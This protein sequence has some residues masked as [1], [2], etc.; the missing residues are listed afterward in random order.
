LIRL[1]AMTRTWKK[2]LLALPLLLVWAW[3]VTTWYFATSQTDEELFGDYRRGLMNA[4]SHGEYKRGDFLAG[5]LLRKPSFNDDQQLLYVAM[6]AANGNQ[7]LPR[8]DLLLSRLTKESHYG[9]AHM[10]YAQQLLGQPNAGAGNLQLAIHHV[11]QALKV[12]D[13]PE[14]IRLYLARLYYQAR[15]STQAIRILEDVTNPSYSS[16]VLLAKLYLSTGAKEKANTMAFELLQQ[17]DL[18]DPTMR[19]SLHE[20]VEAVTVLAESRGEPSFVLSQVAVIAKVLENKIVLVPE[21]ESYQVLLS[22]LY[23]V[24]AKVRLGQVD[25][26]SRGQGLAD[27]QKAIATG[28]APYRIGSMVFSA[29]N[30]DSSGGL[31]EGQM[32][33]ALVQ[34]RGVAV[35]H[36]FLGLDAWK[37]DMMEKAEFHFQLAHAL[38]PETLTVIE[39][40]AAHIAQASTGGTHDALSLSLGSEPRWS[41]AIHL[42][43]L[44]TKID[45]RRLESN[46]RTQCLILS[47]RQRW[48]KIMVL[49][50]PRIEQISDKYRSDFLRL[51]INASRETSDLSKLERYTKMLRAEAQRLKVE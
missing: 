37:K 1:W 8:R 23:L 11:Q 49:L 9:P 24:S 40:V 36:M 7:N 21:N 6:I 25:D 22:Q 46:L 18:E 13:K 50:E 42:L 43:E 27:L 28:K 3:L 47:Q 31:T 45:A 30:L 34:G 35:A 44:C 26:D 5:K 19:K 12:S 4:V 41:R 10:W 38:E 29:S 20:R 33:L 17:L 51:L 39:Y 32:R 48:S 2:L 16:A 15:R 14:P